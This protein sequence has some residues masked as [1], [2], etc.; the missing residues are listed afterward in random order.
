MENVKKEPITLEKAISILKDVFISATERDIYTGD[1]IY[2]NILTKSGITED[3]F[4]L[5]KD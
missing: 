4:Q 5:R 3:R 2:I 1:C